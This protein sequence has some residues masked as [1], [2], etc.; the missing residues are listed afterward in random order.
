VVAERGVGDCQPRFAHP[1]ICEF[2]VTVLIHGRLIEV[3]LAGVLD[4]RSALERVPAR[5]PRH[6]V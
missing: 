6:V 3:V 5:D 2:E 4:E 1:V